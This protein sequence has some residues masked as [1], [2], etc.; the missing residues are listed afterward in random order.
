MFLPD[1]RRWALENPV[2]RSADK[3]NGRGNTPS[4]GFALSGKAQLAT[5]IQFLLRPATA[6]PAS[7][8]NVANP[9]NGKST[10]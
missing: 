10:T 1:S 5:R 2:G 3:K 4:R 6:L 7:H 9:K 8:S